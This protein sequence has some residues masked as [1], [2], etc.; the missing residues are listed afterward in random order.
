MAEWCF[1]H[2]ELTGKSVCL[3]V[4]EQWICG[5]NAPRY[6]HALQQSMRLFLAGCAGL[7]KPVKSTQYEPYPALIPT[8]TG[9]SNAQNQAF[10]QWLGLLK[11]DAVLSS[12]NIRQ[13][14]KLYHQS[15][16]GPL[17]WENLTEVARGMMEPLIRE[18][19]VDW[20]GIA[21]ASSVMDAGA[22]WDRLAVFAEMTSACDMLMVLP[23]KLATELNGDSGFLQGVPVVSHF[24]SQR[25]GIVW[26]FGQNMDW[27]RESSGALALQFDTPWNPPSGDVMGALSVLFDC[28]VR[29][30]YRGQGDGISGYDCYEGGEHVDSAPLERAQEVPELEEPAVITEQPSTQAALLLPAA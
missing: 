25:Y 17:K 26:P 16:L 11:S 27:F 24:Y 14:E 30:W 22:C 23:T 28:Q 9:S 7:L 5:D 3:D 20:F 4:A 18:R 15:G 21:G 12:A 2:V 1:N 29:H 13:I 19:Y 8:G 6:R 10:E